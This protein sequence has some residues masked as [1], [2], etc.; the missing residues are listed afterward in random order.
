MKLKALAIA[1]AALAGSAASASASGTTWTWNFT[2]NQPG[3]NYGVNNVAGTFES[4]T[5]T[6]NTSTQRFTWSSSFSGASLPNGIFM[7]VNDGPNPKGIAGQL[8]IFYIDASGASPRVSAYGYNGQNATTSWQDGNGVAS[9][10]QTPDRIRGFNTSG[11][12]NSLS[13]TTVGGIRTFAL[14]INGAAINSFTSQYASIN[15]PWEGVQFGQ[16]IGVWF[17]SFTGLS[18]AYDANG[19]LTQWNFSQ[20]GWLDGSNFTAVPAPTS[21]AALA[22]AGLLAL[23]RRRAA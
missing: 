19:Y 1:I 23:R 2:K 21:A 18:T 13:V 22:A 9:G 16:K 7:V 12:I 6:Y 3:G 15:N 20:E 14:D 8:A 4:V 10:I 5:S 17:H 11:W